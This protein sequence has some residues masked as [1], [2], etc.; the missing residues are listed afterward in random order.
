MGSGISL[1]AG[2]S[3]NEVQGNFIG[4]NASGTGALPNANDGV[5]LADTNT[6]GNIIGGTVAGARNVISGNTGDGHQL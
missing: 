3:S 1:T 5:E 2:A 4:T 6:T